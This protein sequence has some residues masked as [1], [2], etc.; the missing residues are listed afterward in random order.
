MKI[1]AIETSCDETAVAYLEATGDLPHPE[2]RVL[3]N[4]LI[5]QVPIHK[6]Y[7]GVYPMLAKREHQKNLPL[8]LEQTLKEVGVSRNASGVDAVAV[9]RGP[10][11]EPALWTGVEFAKEL[12]DKW[13]VPLIP[14]NHMEG[15]LWSVLFNNGNTIEFP[16]L[17][18]LVS[19]GHTELVYAGDFKTFKILGRT[20]DDAVGEAFD[21]VARLLGLEYPGGPKISHLARLHRERSIEPSIT[22]TVP[23]KNSKDLDFS[24]SGLKTSVLY[25]VKKLESLDDDTKQ[26]IA[27]S[28]EDA[29]IESLVEKTKQALLSHRARTLIVAG[30]VSANIY[31]REKINELKTEFEDLVVFFPQPELTQDNAVMI[32]ITAYIMKLTSRNKPTSDIEASGNLSFNTV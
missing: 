24:Y 27:R 1:L 5:S 2:F 32:G 26:E 7:G 6:E 14:V 10:G 9:T 25:T 12:A 4:S 22:F 29:A 21:K 18:L 30:G 20:R 15:H 8:L 28:F 11:L 23:M 13:H 31:L 16:L 17:A 19:G 3:G